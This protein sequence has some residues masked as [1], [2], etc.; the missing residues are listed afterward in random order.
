MSIRYYSSN[1]NEE[2]Q[3]DDTIELTL[4]KEIAKGITHYESI[5]L[6]IKRETIP[7]LLKARAIVELNDE[8]LN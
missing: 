8:Y 4:S 6:E 5:E 3:I 1:T 2:L 7:T